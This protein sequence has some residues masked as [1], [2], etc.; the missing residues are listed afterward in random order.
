[1]GGNGYGLIEV[2]W[3]GKKTV[4]KSTKTL[5][6]IADDST[7]RSGRHQQTHK[8][9]RYVTCAPLE[10]NKAYV[11]HTGWSG[12]RIPVKSRSSVPVQTGPGAHTASRVS[13]SGVKRPGRDVDHL[14]P[15]VA[16][17]L[18]SRPIQI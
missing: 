16:V 6:K 15:H 17:R 12:D 18:K 13:F 3:L 1:M 11:L 10:G 9:V 7:T 5:V 4:E 14:L 2:P 8:P